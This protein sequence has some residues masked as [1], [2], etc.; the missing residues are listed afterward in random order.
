MCGTNRYWSETSMQRKLNYL[1]KIILVISLIFL[2]A[3]IIFRCLGGATQE[4]PTIVTSSTLTDAIDISE[5]STA[6]FTYNGVAELYRDENKQKV[7]CHIRYNATIKAGIDMDSVKWEIDET[8][9]TVTPILPEIKI[10]AN[11]VDE[12]TLS[13][14]PSNPKAELST[15]LRVCK[16]D[17]ER[18][19]MESSELVETA[20]ENLKSIIEGLLY[21]ILSPQGYSIVWN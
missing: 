21:P 11:P 7:E 9:K 3:S 15:I 19:A 4:E 8:N 13:F 14:I 17:A 5:L 20:E 16:E 18:E 12:K 1:P 6:Q 2:A 10:T